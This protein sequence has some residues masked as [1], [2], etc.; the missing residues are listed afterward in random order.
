MWF[1]GALALGEA[2]LDR[3]ASLVRTG[4]DA[5]ALLAI[6]ELPEGLAED[7]AVRYLRG[8]LLLEVGRPC[9][10]MDTLARTPSAVPEAIRQ[11]S[12]RRWAHAAARCGQCKEAR[13]VLLGAESSDVVVSRHDR[14]VAAECAAQMGEL[15][16]AAEELERLTRRNGGENRVALLS[17]LA[18][19]YVDLGRPEEAREAALRAWKVSLSPDQQRLAETLL[20]GASPTVD[21]RLDRAESL[22]S[23][24]HFERAAEE[25]EALG[26]RTVASDERRNARWHHL[27]GMAL[28]RMR[29]RYLDAARVLHRSAL[30]GS[31]TEIEDAFHSARAL[32]RADKDARAIAA[33]RRFAT[34]YPKSKRA[35]EAR[36]LAAWL[37]I[38]LG[39]SNGERQMETLVRGRSQVY[40]RWRRS[41]SWELGF[42]A[43]ETR[44]YSRAVKFLTEYSALATTAMDQARAHYWLGRAYRR[45]PKAIAEYRQA[46]GIEPLHWYAVLAASRLKQ[47]GVAPPAPFE[48]A[49][50]SSS[51]ETPSVAPPLPPT[52]LAYRRLGLDRDAIAWLGA[53]EQLLVQEVEKTSRIPTLARLYGDAGAYREAMVVARRRMSLLHSNPTLS[54]WWWEAMYPMPWLQIVDAHRGDLPRGL[55]YA[56]MRQESGFQSDVIS[57]AGAVGLMQVMPEL[58]SKLAGKPM[59][60]TALRDPATNIDLGLRE[61]AALAAELDH[62]YPLSIAAYNAGKRRVRRWLAESGR[63]ELDRFVE[64]IPFNETRNYVRRV[65]THYARY[66]YLDDASSGWPELPPFVGP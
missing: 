63:M 39:R 44:R 45:G 38:R 22:M 3:V 53:H 15:E 14:A 48:E 36:F 21:D 18:E 51:I 58:A 37:E 62:V 56:T 11:D 54:R 35:A 50:S 5:A 31:A 2:G 8:R 10:A 25:L 32:S 4:D 33:Y 59:T 34:K 52:F 65:T 26:A 30:L 7:D 28:F 64:R 19:V 40:G 43:I 60:R 17:L 41:A 6:G 1:V 23:A 47:L 42:R 16:R 20:D 29:T 24:R 46:I 55:V 57:R 13:P 49:S 66:S 27:Y 61:M 9:D 12:A